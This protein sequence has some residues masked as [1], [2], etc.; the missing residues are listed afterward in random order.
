MKK[1][2]LKI[3]FVADPVE[4]FNPQV[5]TTFFLMAEACRRGHQV[6]AFEPKQIFCRTHVGARH[7]SPLRRGRTQ[8]SPLR[9]DVY[10]LMRR[11]EVKSE[12]K[13]FIFKW[14][15]ER[16]P[17]P[18]EKLDCLFLRK[19]PP[20]DEA[21][22]QHLHLLALAEGK[23]LMVNSPT[24]ILK[25]NEKIFPFHFSGL[26]PETVVAADP[27]ILLGAVRTFKK[28]VVKPLNSSGGRGVL[29]LQAGDKNVKSLLEMA[30]SN[31][32]LA[33]MV[34]KFIPQVSQGDKRILL[35][36][37]DPI[38]AFLRVPTGGDFRA[39]LHSGGRK[40]RTT[41]TLA[42]QK[43][44]A[45]LKP[46]LVSQGLFFVGVDVIGGKVTEINTT[47]PMGIGETNQFE[48]SQIEKNVLNWV[49]DTLF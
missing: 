17:L 16:Q 20:V 46:L 45:E 23:L 32:A 10:A 22:I 30:T 37:G 24:G 14:K 43:I 38:G 12:N 3:G 26:S 18:V 33:V 13:K 39:N 5:E 31:F 44:V 7:A 42:D 34:Q 11:I 36:A 48:N 27:Q 28:C 49:E 35:L 4:S 19:D 29:L 40:K 6:F 41:L 2:Q 15:A 9:T 21:F 47:S 1:T 25:A 8:G